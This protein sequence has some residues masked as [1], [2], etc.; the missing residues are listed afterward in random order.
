M[1]N[2]IRRDLILQKK[3]LI[4]YVPFILLFI[5]TG[6]NP[7]LIYLLSSILI[8]FNAYAYDEKTQTNILL[9]SLPYTRKEIV[10]A[11]YI[12][13]II[14]MII[15]M[16]I[17]NLLL[18][19]FGQSF[20]I[21]QMAIG[22]GLFILFSAIA[23]PLF[24]IIKPGHISTV[25]MITLI[26]LIFTGPSLYFYIV[27]QLPFITDAVNRLSDVTLYSS[28]IIFVIFSYSISWLITIVI[29]QRKVF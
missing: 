12:G 10:T 18:V 19:I 16:V 22:S 26:F 5:I 17:T 2:L 27:E 28:A 24:Y 14:F 23:F 15:S 1:Y 9:N 8:P 7:A 4:F 21:S 25:L 11:R 6:K 29:Y 20:T 13:A 3:Q